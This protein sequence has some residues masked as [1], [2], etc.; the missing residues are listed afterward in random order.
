MGQGE[1]S[2]GPQPLGSSSGDAQLGPGSQLAVSISQSMES[3]SSALILG[4]SRKT[5]GMVRKPREAG[6]R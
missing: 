2:S 3:R 1:G 5:K 6:A 4:Y